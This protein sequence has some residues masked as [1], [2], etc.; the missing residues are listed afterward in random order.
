[1]EYPKYELTL[2]KTYY[3]KGFFNL[4]ISVDNYIQSKNGLIHILLG[5]S[6]EEING[7]LNRDANLNSTPRIHGG[8]ELKHWIQNNFNLKDLVLVHILAPDTVWITG[9][10]N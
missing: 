3:N 9:M 6:R 7:H 8:N 4:G 5:K 1:M 10:E 2:H